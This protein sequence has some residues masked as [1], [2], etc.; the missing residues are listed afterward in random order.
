MS[1]LHLLHW[2]NISA[3]YFQQWKKLWVMIF[4]PSFLVLLIQRKVT[5]F[6]AL[7]HPPGSKKLL[8]DANTF[9]GK[10]GLMALGSSAP[11]DTTELFIH[12]VLEAQISP[13]H[14]LVWGENS[15]SSCFTVNS[16]QLQ[17]KWTDK[18]E[19][20]QVPVPLFCDV[21]FFLKYH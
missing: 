21:F 8:K 19:L 18:T 4:L 9:S 3:Y 20:S 7:V 16:Y 1:T 5:Y 11:G 2:C 15:I 10:R 17:I 12:L 14:G 6:A 13:E